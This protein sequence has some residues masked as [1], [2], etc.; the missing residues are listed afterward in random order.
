MIKKLISVKFLVS[1]VL[2]QV[3]DGVEGSK[4]KSN[5][6]SESHAR[7]IKF[8]LSI[9]PNNVTE[10][11]DVFLRTEQGEPEHK[12]SFSVPVIFNDSSNKN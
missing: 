2:D 8:D 4:F 3:L 1:N 12:I 10:S 6:Q 9:A 5:Y 11:K 7:D